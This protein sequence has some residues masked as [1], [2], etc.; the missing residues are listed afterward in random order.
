[1][2]AKRGDT[3]YIYS[4]LLGGENLLPMKQANISG[5]IGFADFGV[6]PAFSAFQSSVGRFVN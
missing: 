6:V 3:S 2:M 1:M 4:S 5:I